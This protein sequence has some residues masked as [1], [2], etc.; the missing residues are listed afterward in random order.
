LRENGVLQKQLSNIFGHNTHW[1]SNLHHRTSRRVLMQNSLGTLRA[2]L[3]LDTN[4]PTKMK[5]KTM[6]TRISKVVLG[7]LCIASIT[8]AAQTARA[9]SYGFAQI[10]ANGNQ[11]VASQLSVDVTGAGG[12][13]TFTFY[14]LGAI[15]SSITDIYFDDGTLLG[16]SGITDSGAG[17]AFASPASPGNLPGASSASPPFVTT[18]NFSADSSSPVLANGVNNSVS[19]W[20]AITFQLINGN[21]YND[22]LAALGSGAL[23]IGL[24]VQGIGTQ[25]GSESFVN[26]PGGD[27]PT[28]PDGGSTVALL[29]GALAAVGAVG[30]RFRKS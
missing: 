20:V 14:N 12:S 29:G 16:I 21:T 11:L 15:A 27:I 30:R 3:L 5:V 24:H 17:V 25:G 23:R 8:V 1:I 13:A 18:Q 22:T 28:T 4:K 19:E 9:A 7:A 10:T 6:K 26:T 2:S